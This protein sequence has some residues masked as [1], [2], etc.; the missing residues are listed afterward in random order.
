MGMIPAPSTIKVT[1]LDKRH[2]GHQW[3][4]HRATFDGNYWSRVNNFCAARDWCVDR[5]GLSREINFIGHL[6]DKPRPVWAWQTE[7]SYLRLYLTEEAMTH[8]AFV[9]DKFKEVET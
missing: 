4:T 2:T 8:F 3:Y 9:M 5:F 6:R 1:R 7:H